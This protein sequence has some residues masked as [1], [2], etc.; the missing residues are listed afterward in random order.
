MSS[1]GQYRR[2]CSPVA[3]EWYS[4]VK[5]GVVPQLWLA[6]MKGKA[7]LR[8][9]WSSRLIS[10]QLDFTYSVAD[11]TPS[12]DV[13]RFLLG[14]IVPQKTS[15]L[16]ADWLT[17]PSVLQDIPQTAQADIIKCLQLGF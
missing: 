3:F 5:V 2:C 17:T 1:S 10:A 9:L 4:Y 8:A 12:T 11:S 6:S 15:L 14:N 13:G 7:K 16:P